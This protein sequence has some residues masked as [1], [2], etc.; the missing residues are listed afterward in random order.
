MFDIFFFSSLLG[1]DKV[2]NYAVN[3]WLVDI[4]RNQVYSIMGGVSPVHTLLQV[5]KC[6]FKWIF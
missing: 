1:F 3:E 2:V 6:L 4:R 5:C